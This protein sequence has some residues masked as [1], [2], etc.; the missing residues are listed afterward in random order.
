MHSLRIVLALA[1][2]TALLSGCGN[3]GA[4]VIPDQDKDKKDQP[5][6]PPGDAAKPAD[7]R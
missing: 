7:S 5:A 3:K 6:T 2:C 1:L 4:L